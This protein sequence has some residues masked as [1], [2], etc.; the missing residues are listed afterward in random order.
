TVTLTE[1]GHSQVLGQ[2][3]V[4]FKWG[5]VEGAHYYQVKIK[6]N[7]W[8]GDSIA[9][10]QVT[11]TSFSTDLDDGKYIWG[12][13]A[14]DTV[15]KKRTDYSLRNFS[16]DKNAPASPIPVHPAQNDTINASLVRLSWTMPEE[17]LT[18]TYEV[19]SDAGLTTLLI[20][21]QATDTTAM[22]S[23]TDEGRYFWRVKAT[24]KNNNTGSFSTVSS[25]VVKLIPDI[26]QSTVLLRSP[27]TSA[28]LTVN[29]VTFWWEEV[30][31]AEKY[32]LQVVSPGFDQTGNLLVN[33]WAEETTRAL[34]LPAGTYQWRVKAANSQYSTNY[35]TGN[36]SIYKSDIASQL[37][38]LISPPDGSLLNYPQVDFQWMKI[39]TCGYQFILKK[40]EWGSGTEIQRK[41]LN[42]TAVGFMLTDGD[43]NWGVKAIDPV[44]QTETE[45]AFRSFTIDKTPPAVPVPISPVNNSE[46]MKGEITFQWQSADPGQ[47]GIS[48]VLKLYRQNGTQNILVT[49]QTGTSADYTYHFTESGIYFWQVRA[50]DKANNTS[51]FS[52]LHKLVVLDNNH[53][54]EGKIV[55]LKAP[56]NGYESSKPEI[57]F[58][59]DTVEDAELYLFQLVKPNFLNIEELIREVNLATNQITLQLGPGTYQWRVKAKNSTSETPFSG[60]FPVT[61]KEAD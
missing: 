39:G 15:H 7:N 28:P 61:V 54:L 6:K 9:S 1:P 5:Q 57:T 46:V 32:L 33:E 40:G 17:D 18:Y 41:K 13:A 19:H 59:W 36:F 56:Y 4:S 42:G 8:G 21:N 47:E 25:F 51:G 23:F 35:S 3:F 24:D 27:N 2:S 12:V 31:G 26:S 11:K 49:E 22:V 16:I 20:S 52:A 58:W 44:D 10:G 50:F 38:E 60:I 29:M 37:V 34:E 43:Y 53:S 30:P 48:Y 55:T 14:V 45:F